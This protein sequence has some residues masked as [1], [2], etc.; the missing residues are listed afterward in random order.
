MTKVIIVPYRNRKFQLKNFIENVVPLF[1]KNI[2]NVEIKIIEQEEGKPF[3]R[4]QLLNVGFD[5]CKNYCSYI[6]THDIDLIPNEEQIIKFYKNPEKEVTR[7]FSG[8]DRSCGGICIFKKES[9]EKVNGFHSIWG[10]GIEDVNIFFRCKYKNIDVSENYRIPLKKIKEDH[11][12]IRNITYKDG[13]IVYTP[14][15]KKIQNDTIDIYYKGN[16]LEKEKYLMSSGLNTLEYKIL[17]T[18]IV[19][20][21]IEIIKVSI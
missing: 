14:I 21:N 19:Q 16:N 7:I 13:N 20:N 5:I 15:R 17:E 6:I 10:W 4:G 1:K 11:F 18:T 9:F 2:E 8:H 3:N 12:A